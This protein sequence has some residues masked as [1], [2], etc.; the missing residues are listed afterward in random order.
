[1]GW[2]KTTWFKIVFF[3]LVKSFPPGQALI[4]HNIMTVKYFDTD[5]LSGKYAAN[6][7]ASWESY[8][9][10]DL[11]GSCMRYQYMMY[12]KRRRLKANW[13]L[14][15]SC[16]HVCLN[17]RRRHK[18]FHSHFTIWVLKWV[19]LHMCMYKDSECVSVCRCLCFLWLFLHICH[20]VVMSI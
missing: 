5:D 15:E 11:M 9:S 4:I 1:M 16:V 2:I 17:K 13:L 12:L 6:F 18:M 3:S 7:V 10:L 19:L 20:S 8:H 14:L